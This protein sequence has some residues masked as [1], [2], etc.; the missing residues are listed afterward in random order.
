MPE[1]SRIQTSRSQPVTETALLWHF[2]GRIYRSQVQSE[3]GKATFRLFR[4]LLLLRMNDRV[5][6][7]VKTK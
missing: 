5:D 7:E 3:G 6:V 4:L 1:S 2:W